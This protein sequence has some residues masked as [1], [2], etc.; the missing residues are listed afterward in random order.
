M[1]RIQ[2]LCLPAEKGG[3]LLFPFQHQKFSCPAN[4]SGITQSITQTQ[5]F[6]LLSE[7]NLDSRLRNMPEYLA[8]VIPRENKYF[9]H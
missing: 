4:P 2:S 8:W 6:L 7:Y 3:S 9:V 1:D 5:M